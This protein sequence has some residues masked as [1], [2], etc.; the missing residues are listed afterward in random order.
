MTVRYQRSTPYHLS[1]ILLSVMCTHVSLCVHLPLH[2]FLTRTLL[3]PYRG[4]TMCKC[5]DP[6]P[7]AHQDEG[8]YLDHIAICSSWT[9]TSMA[10]GTRR[11]FVEVPCYI[12]HEPL[13]GQTVAP[14][15]SNA[16]FKPLVGSPF[17]RCVNSR[18]LNNMELTSVSTE[19]GKGSGCFLT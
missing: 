2:L 4:D 6:A 12:Y 1:V 17:A 7:S 5:S 9:W 13:T 19:D 16:T 3:H 15:P 8:A 14:A 10:E 11:P 18:I